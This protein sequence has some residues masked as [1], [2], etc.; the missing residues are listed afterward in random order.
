[1]KLNQFIDE[2]NPN[3][4]SNGGLNTVSYESESDA[5]LFGHLHDDASANND[6]HHKRELT[7]RSSTSRDTQDFNDFETIS[8]VSSANSI[9]HLHKL[10]ATTAITTTTP[11]KAPLRPSQK[12][13]T[14]PESTIVQKNS[15]QNG[16]SKGPSKGNLR[17]YIHV[18]NCFTIST[19]TTNKLTIY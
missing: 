10:T 2:D 15:L 3:I 6:I 8:S 12:A 7:T 1:M 5:S 14:G 13:S 11:S 19:T 17:S 4:N 16:P 9:S 18:N